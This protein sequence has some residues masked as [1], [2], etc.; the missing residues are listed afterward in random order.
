MHGITEKKPG[1]RTALRSILGALLASAP[2]A[3]ASLAGDQQLVDP[4]H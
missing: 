3:A 1:L 4:G 2:A